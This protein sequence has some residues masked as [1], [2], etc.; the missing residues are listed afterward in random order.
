MRDIP[1]FSHE[2]APFYPMISNSKPSGPVNTQIT[3][4][5]TIRQGRAILSMGYFEIKVSCTTR[6]QQDEAIQT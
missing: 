5:H 2:Q 4:T 1:A 6:A 3:G